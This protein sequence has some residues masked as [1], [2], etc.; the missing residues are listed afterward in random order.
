MFIGWLGITATLLLVAAL[1]TCL[2]IAL[3]AVRAVDPGIGVASALTAGASANL[4]FALPITGIAGLGPAQ[5]AWATALN[6]AGT[7]WDTAIATAL[8]GHAIVLTGALVLGGIA[9]VLPAPEGNRVDS[10]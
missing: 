1:Y 4:A 7:G 8:A 10:R 5:A 2:G 3:L 9:L 6:L